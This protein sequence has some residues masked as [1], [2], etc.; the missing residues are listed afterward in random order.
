MA[1]RG[2]LGLGSAR[3]RAGPVARARALLAMALVAQETD[4]FVAARGHLLP[5]A[6]TA[7]RHAAVVSRAPPPQVAEDDDD[8]EMDERP[9]LY[10]QGLTEWDGPV[11]LARRIALTLGFFVPAFILLDALRTSELEGARNQVAKQ[12][13]LETLREDVAVREGYAESR[14]A[15]RM[16]I[17]L[18]PPEGALSP[19]EAPAPGTAPPTTAESLRTVLREYRKPWAETLP[20][21]R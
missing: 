15:Y 2:G 8:D 20:W 4:G 18:D 5:R 1:R 3:P 14:A 9:V 21:R 16:R 10:L 6:L 13:I 12:E 19:A 11:D 7:A 17:G